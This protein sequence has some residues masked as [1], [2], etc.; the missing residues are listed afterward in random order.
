[1]VPLLRV[2]ADPDWGMYAVHAT[3]LR[4]ARICGGSLDIPAATSVGDG[5]RH[6]VAFLRIAV[7]IAGRRLGRVLRCAL[8]RLAR[9]ILF[10]PAGLL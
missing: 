5:S 1:M 4:G 2:L 7:S 8:F 9:P 3:V 10:T 6:A